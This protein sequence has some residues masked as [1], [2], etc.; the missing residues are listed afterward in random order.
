MYTGKPGS[1][2]SYRVV[3]QLLRDSGRYYVFHNIAGLREAMIEDGQ[4]IQRWDDIPQFFSKTKQE[5]IC[6]WVKEKYNRST[7]IVIDEAQC[8]FGERN[9][10]YRAWLSWH[11]HL[12]QD[13]WLVC[14]H[15]KMLHSDYYNLADYECRGKRGIATGQFVYQ[16]S[17]GVS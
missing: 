3:Y 4:Y 13:I 9:A 5:E 17:V 6:K 1:G 11:R 14:Q 2:K 12:G 16:Y 15:Y 7:L 10:E 8:W